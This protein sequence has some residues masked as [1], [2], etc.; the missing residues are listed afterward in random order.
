MQPHDEINSLGVP[1]GDGMPQHNDSDSP[2]KALLPSPDNQYIRSSD[3]GLTSAEEMLDDLTASVAE[4]MQALEARI[5]DLQKTMFL[6]LVEVLQWKKDVDERLLSLGHFVYNTN[7]NMLTNSRPQPLS[8]SSGDHE[9]RQSGVE[10]RRGLMAEWQDVSKSQM[11]G[12]ERRIDGAERSVQKV[13]NAPEPSPLERSQSVQKRSNSMKTKLQ[14]PSERFASS[15]SNLP[16]PPTY[17]ALSR[18]TL[19]RKAKEIEG[20]DEEEE[21]E[22]RTKKKAQGHQNSEKRTK[23]VLRAKKQKMEDVKQKVSEISKG[24]EY[25]KGKGEEEEPIKKSE[26]TP[27]NTKRKAEEMEENE[28]DTTEEEETKKKPAKRAKVTLKNKEKA[29]TTNTEV[30]EPLKDTN[31]RKATAP[32]PKKKPAPNPVP[33]TSPRYNFRGRKSTQP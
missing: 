3:G 18:K 22:E 14:E 6:K 21:G 30:G 24:A 25:E 20:E 31:A 19:K 26:A 8:N 5:E 4:N 11:L 23:L 7:S 33:P 17:D 9:N 10:E 29:K 13:R 15:S 2:N 27:K 1:T 12:N 28:N 16:G 32:K